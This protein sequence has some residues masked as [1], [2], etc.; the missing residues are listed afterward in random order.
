MKNSNEQ[1]KGQTKKCPKCQEVIQ[2]GAKKCKHCGADL[3]N[4][5]VK[6]KIINGI[7]IL[8][9]IVSISIAIDGCESS[10]QSNSNSAQTNETKENKKEAEKFDETIDPLTTIQDNVEET[11][12]GTYTYSDNSG[13]FEITISGDRWYSKLTIVTGFGSDYD[14]QRAEHNSGIVNGN[15]LYYAEGM[16]AMKI[17]YVSGRSLIYQRLTLRKNRN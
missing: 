10:K 16:A 11:I 14:S 6:H 8:W 17:G 15:D 3:R 13:E 12:D 4:W 2:L 1:S 9:V 7:L 5:F